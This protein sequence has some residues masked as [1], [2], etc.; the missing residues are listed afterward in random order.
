VVT[1]T[2]RRLV[3][4]EV[5]WNGNREPLRN[6]FAW[7]PHQSIIR[8]SWT[9]HTKYQERFRSAMVSP[10]FSHITFIRPE[11]NA[12]AERWLLTVRG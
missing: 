7:D 4:R 5:L 9:Q 6:L 12:H 3:R 1:R 10:A 8:W 11:S 2:L